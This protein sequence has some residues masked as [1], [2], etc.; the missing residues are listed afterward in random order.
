M[1][2]RF[3]SKVPYRRMYQFYYNDRTSKVGIGGKLK[4]K[5]GRKR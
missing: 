1:R 3:E 2:G 4:A 5:R